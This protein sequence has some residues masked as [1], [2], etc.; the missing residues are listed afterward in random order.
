MRVVRLTIAVAAVATAA[1]LIAVTPA[2]A[3]PT[4]PGTTPTSTPLTSAV[5]AP[6]NLDLRHGKVLVAD[7]GP[8]LIGVLKADGTVRTVVGE[9][10]GASGVAAARHG[11]QLAY[12]TT[13]GGE[14]G[15]IAS[16]LVV[17]GPGGR[18]VMADTLAHEKANNPDGSVHYGVTNPSPCVTEEFSNAGFPVSYRGLI[19][20]HAYSVAAH[21]KGW[22]VA[23]AGANA[24]FRVSRTGRVSTLAV[25]PAH[26]ATITAE[27]AQAFGLADCVIGVRY[28][29]ESVPTDVEVGP[30]GFLYV[31]TLPGGPEDA[32]LGARGKVFRVDP[33]TGRFKEVASGFLGATNLAISGGRIYVTELFAGRISLV[34]HGKAAAFFDL[35]GALAVEAGPHGSL[36]AATGITGPPS[37]VRI[38]PGGKGW[39]KHRT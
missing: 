12:T 17:A 16:G 36:Y 24:L 8:G 15:I 21:G 2:G 29:F 9:V 10:P 18:H 35:P 28:A 14:G 13:E 32:S 19:D 3:H 34:R 25:L 11:R 1:S 39:K 7:G 6:F 4:T 26:P 23:D 27:A 5:G 31:T 30:D 20:S 38:D 37:V 22:I 33:R